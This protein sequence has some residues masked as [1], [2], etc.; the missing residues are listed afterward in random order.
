M[1][2]KTKSDVGPRFVARSETESV[3][4][5]C[6]STIRA[7]RYHPLQDAEDI[8]ADVCLVRPDSAVQY[9]IL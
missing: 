4:I 1:E 5:F 7:D 3:C 8:H 2:D 6:S 9:A